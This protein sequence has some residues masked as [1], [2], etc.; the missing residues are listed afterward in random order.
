MSD[1]KV[2]TDQEFADQ[3]AD[4]SVSIMRED[5]LAG[6]PFGLSDMG[7][8]PCTVEEWLSENKIVSEVIYGTVSG[9]IGADMLLD[10]GSISVL[11]MARRIS[12]S[13]EVYAGEAF[14]ERTIPDEMNSAINDHMSR[15][16]GAL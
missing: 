13:V 9:Y 11:I 5:S 15:L 10:H 14:A 16:Q 8:H 2:I 3:C 12:G 7:G 1:Y 6:R 4:Q